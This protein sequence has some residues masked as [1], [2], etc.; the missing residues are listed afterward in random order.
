MAP[1]FKILI[2]CVCVC[3]LDSNIA[4]LEAKIPGHE[5]T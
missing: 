2:M 1:D 3:V 5:M 4:S